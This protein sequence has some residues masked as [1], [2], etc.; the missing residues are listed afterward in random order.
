MSLHF[1]T[2]IFVLSHNLRAW[3]L[4]AALRTF[5]HKCDRT[6]TGRLSYRDL[7]MGL[8]SY[9]FNITQDSYAR[10]FK[11][12][13][14]DKSGD[15]NYN[16][17]VNFFEHSYPLMPPESRNLAKWQKEQTTD[18]TMTAAPY[19]T[20]VPVGPATPSVTP[21]HPWSHSSSTGAASD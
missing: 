14:A 1:C 2:Y 6:G 3:G 5:F 13:D 20:D 8:A 18:N 19:A 10:L 12:L 21:P 4:Q 9:N 16:E 15:V 7:Y 11:A 17:F